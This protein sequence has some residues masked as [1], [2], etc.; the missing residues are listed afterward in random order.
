MPPVGKGLTSSS[1][2]S[3]LWQA[4][5]DDTGGQG[6]DGIVSDPVPLATGG[7]DKLRS[8]T[9]SDSNTISWFSLKGD[10]QVPWESRGNG[11]H[12]GIASRVS[13]QNVLSKGGSAHFVMLAQ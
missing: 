12:G 4:T 5:G 9:R 2:T 7:G 13:L 3:F 10:V 8:L 11:L 6:A 1:L